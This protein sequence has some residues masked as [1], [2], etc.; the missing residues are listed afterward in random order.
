MCDVLSCCPLVDGQGSATYETLFAR[1]PSTRIHDN[2]SPSTVPLRVIMRVASAYSGWATLPPR[3]TSVAQLV[4]HP[5]VAFG[6][7][8]A[9]VVMVTLEFVRLRLLSRMYP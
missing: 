7:C 6:S 8:V 5:Y 9:F 2:V 1:L 4:P 3:A